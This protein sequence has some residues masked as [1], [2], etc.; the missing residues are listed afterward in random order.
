MS[1]INWRDVAAGAATYVVIL[2]AIAA[3]MLAASTTAP[4]DPSWAATH[5]CQETTP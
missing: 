1:R 5:G 3:L 4:D 2:G